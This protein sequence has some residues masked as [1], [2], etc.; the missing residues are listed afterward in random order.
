MNYIKNKRRRTSNTLFESSPIWVLCK[1]GISIFRLYWRKACASS[2]ALL[3]SL[4]YVFSFSFF[5]QFTR[6]VS[7]LHPVSI[8][9]RDIFFTVTWFFYLSQTISLFVYIYNSKWKS[10]SIWRCDYNPF[11]RKTAFSIKSRREDENPVSE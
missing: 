11:S 4:S 6:T 10:F 2:I 5:F 8:L 7:V 1:A 3:T 9:R